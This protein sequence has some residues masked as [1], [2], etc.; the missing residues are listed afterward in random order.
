MKRI[1]QKPKTKI[2]AAL[3]LAVLGF[4]TVGS[5]A[6]AATSGNRQDKLAERIATKFNLDKNQVSSELESFHQEEQTERHQERKQAL[7]DA[8]Q[9]KVDDG[10]ITADQK[11][12]IEA[13][14]EEKHQAREAEREANK[15]SETKPTRDEMKAKMDSDKAELEAWLK[16]QSINLSLEEVMPKPDHRERGRGHVA[17][18]KDQ[19]Q[20]SASDSSN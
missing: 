16:E 7:A 20:D 17:D 19:N 10:V 12:A 13:K 6:F 14:L 4:S 11:T 9:K 5:V 2:T 15:N 1:L 18:D 8:L 3:L